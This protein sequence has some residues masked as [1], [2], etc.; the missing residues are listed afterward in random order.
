M[1]DLTASPIVDMCFYKILGI[2]PEHGLVVIHI[3]D[4]T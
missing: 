1:V 3:E 4:M 2:P